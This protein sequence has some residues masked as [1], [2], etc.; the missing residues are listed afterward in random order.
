MLFSNII[1]YYE[2]Y[3]KPYHNLNICYDQSHNILDIPFF[4]RNNNELK[5]D[6][7]KL[8]NNNEKKEITEN[9][10]LF[11]TDFHFNFH[12]FMLEMLYLLFFYTKHYSSYKLCIQNNMANF[13]LEYLECLNINLSRIIKLEEKTNYKFSVV[14]ILTNNFNIGKK[15]QLIENLNKY[16]NYK[17]LVYYPEKIFL[18]RKNNKRILINKDKIYD[19]LKKKNYYFYSPEESNLQ[20]QIAL[21]RNCKVLCCELGAGCCNMF[22]LNKKAKLFILSF[23]KGWTNKYLYYNNIIKLDISVIHGKLINGNE[24]NCNWSVNEK[25]VFDLL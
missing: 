3:N 22:F 5:F 25:E 16:L 8:I 12:H 9:C 2:T 18:F 11:V 17:P 1:F 21:M 14:K 13:A 6:T 20:T 24:H 10:F 19:I 7:K 15:I 23:I 4:Y